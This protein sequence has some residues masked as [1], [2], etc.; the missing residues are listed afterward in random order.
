MHDIHADNR[1]S[2]PVTEIRVSHND[3]E[4]TLKGREAWAMHALIQG[5]PRGITSL[6]NPAP[7]MAHYVFKL[8]GGGFDIA[9]IDEPHGGAFAGSHAR[10]V[11]RSTV[12]V[13]S[14][15]RKNDRVSA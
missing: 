6:S 10:Y 5:G 12:S 13:L 1:D 14:V 2:N 9:T 11:L 4:I 3:R 15:T 7:R 8:R